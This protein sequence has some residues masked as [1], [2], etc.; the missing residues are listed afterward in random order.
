MIAID[1][2]E[3]WMKKIG[4]RVFLLPKDKDALWEIFLEG[5]NGF[6]DDFMEDGRMP[7]IEVIREEL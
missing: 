7:E 1:D 2:D 3:V 6:S 4:K 5:L